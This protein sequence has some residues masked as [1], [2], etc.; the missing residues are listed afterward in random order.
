MISLIKSPILLF[1]I[2]SLSNN[3]QVIQWQ[4][5]S[6]EFILVKVKVQN[7]HIY[8]DIY[9]TL[10]TSYKKV[11]AEV[12]INAK[13]MSWKNILNYSL[14]QPVFLWMDIGI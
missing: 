1:L 3:T 9:A 12:F 5:G 14:I 11:D 10:C 13:A 7:K 2:A 4:T 6:F 8:A